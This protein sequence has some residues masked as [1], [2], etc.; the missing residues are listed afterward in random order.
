MQIDWFDLNGSADNSWWLSDKPDKEEG[1][2]PKPEENEGR[3]AVVAGM[4]EDKGKLPESTGIK[5]LA[6]E[7]GVVSTA[8]TE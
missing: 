7:L 3:I 5:N 8:D 4:A 1:T 6:Q 2:K